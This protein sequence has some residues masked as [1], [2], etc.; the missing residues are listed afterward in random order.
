LPPS[1]TNLHQK[2]RDLLLHTV[3]LS[4]AA[5]RPIEHFE[6]SINEGFRLLR[7]IDEH[8]DENSV[9]EKVYEKHLGHLRRMVL[10]QLITEKNEWP[11]Y[12]DIHY[13]RCLTQASGPVGDLRPGLLETA[14]QA[15][16]LSWLR[17]MRCLHPSQRRFRFHGNRCFNGT[18][19]ERFQ[20]TA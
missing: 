2:I 5:D 14:L 8:I 10:A 7:Y 16:S 12:R 3:P 11:P 15:E 9:A 6:E 17:L 20:K 4:K 18:G 19:G 1:P 13:L